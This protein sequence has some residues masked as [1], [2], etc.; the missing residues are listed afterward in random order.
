MTRYVQPPIKGGVEKPPRQCKPL[1]P[2][3]SMFFDWSALGLS[4]KTAP[5]VRKGP[6]KSDKVVDNEPD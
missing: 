2:R 1:P 6:K 5:I 4:K 3:N